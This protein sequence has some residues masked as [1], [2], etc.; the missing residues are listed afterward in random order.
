M[1]PEQKPS[2]RF[3]K[4][5]KTLKKKTVG[6]I[7]LLIGFSYKEESEFGYSVQI[8]WFLQ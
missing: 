6:D 3:Q 4:Q 2:R 1:Y 7:R 5:Q 8:M